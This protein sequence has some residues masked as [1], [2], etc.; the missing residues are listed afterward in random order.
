F[1]TPPDQ[2]V[3]FFVDAITGNIIT[4]IHDDISIRP[5]DFILQPAYPNPITTNQT[6]RIPFSLSRNAEVEISLYNLLGQ[7]IRQISL[8]SKT[9]G[10]YAVPLAALRENL[11]AG[12]YFVRMR[13]RENTGRVRIFSQRLLIK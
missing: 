13:V 8:G 6:L 10:E 7:R 11:A 5:Q 12:V 2:I 3:S 1:L 4:D 9:A